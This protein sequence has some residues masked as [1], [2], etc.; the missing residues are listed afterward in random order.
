MLKYS[1][2]VL[3]GNQ[4][5]KSICND[6]INHYFEVYFHFMTTLTFQEALLYD[7]S[8]FSRSAALNRL[9]FFLFIKNRIKISRVGPN[10]MV[11]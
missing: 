7:N 2:L 10:F 3:E 8:Y 11:G 9:F 4:M 5:Y 1:L 6:T